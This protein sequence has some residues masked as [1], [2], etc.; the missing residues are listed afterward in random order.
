MSNIHKFIEDESTPEPIKWLFRRFVSEFDRQNSSAWYEQVKSTSSEYHRKTLLK[1]G[2]CNFDMPKHNLTGKELIILYN[3]YYFPMHYQSSF[4]IFSTLITQYLK[5][6]NNTFFFHDYGCGTLSSTMA[7]GAC[8]QQVLYCYM[9]ESE[10]IR[11]NEINYLRPIGHEYSY[12][13]IDVLNHMFYIKDTDSFPYIEKHELG[14][15]RNAGGVQYF[16]LPNFINGYYLFDISSEIINYLDEFLQESCYAEP[17]QNYFFNTASCTDGHFYFQ[18]IADKFYCSCN[19][20]CAEPF[21]FMSFCNDQKKTPSEVNVIIN[22]S[23]VLASDSVKIENIKALIVEYQKTG[24]NL[25]IV[26]Q[27]PDLDILN[28]KW[29]VLKKGLQFKPVVKGTQAIKHFSSK[30]KSRFEIIALSQ[31]DYR[32]DYSILLANL[33]PN[34]D[35]Y[36]AIIIQSFIIKNDVFFQKKILSILKHKDFCLAL[37]IPRLN[38][39]SISSFYKISDVIMYFEQN[40]NQIVALCNQ[41]KIKILTDINFIDWLLN[42]ITR[43]VITWEDLIYF[44]DSDYITAIP[45]FIRLNIWDKILQNERLTNEFITNDF[46]EGGLYLNDDNFNFLFVELAI[47]NNYQYLITDYD[48]FQYYQHINNVLRARYF[49]ENIIYNNGYGGLFRQKVKQDYLNFMAINFPKDKYHERLN[50]FE[51]PSFNN[52]L[53]LPF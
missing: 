12:N 31:E 23:Y 42:E 26:N 2:R 5:S 41:I 44:F 33:K 7:F 4:E 16:D 38:E 1:Q 49:I 47:K 40:H 43:N 29:E 51:K 53:D 45:V 3:Y 9:T 37:K 30:S 21:A 50:N 10:L 11:N 14:K 48:L 18:N 22:F 27:N 46:F 34:D 28:H 17:N 19:Q 24:C 25:I 39:E 13:H 32:E 8:L 20:F 6:N 35:D 36:N 15:I 52:D